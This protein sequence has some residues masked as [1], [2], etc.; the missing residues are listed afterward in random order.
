M[1]VLITLVLTEDKGIEFTSSLYWVLVGNTLAL[2][3]YI[4]HG[5]I[6]N[7]VG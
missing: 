1:T 6:G 2:V 4:V 3:G 5:W 7:R